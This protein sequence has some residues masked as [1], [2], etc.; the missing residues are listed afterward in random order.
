MRHKVK[1]PKL[2]DTTQSVLITKWL[3]SVGDDVEIGTPILEVETDKITTEVTSPV[4]GR[5]VELLVSLQDEV[6]IGESIC[7]VEA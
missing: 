4:S 6:N 1:L 2:G 3:C 7:V 5:L